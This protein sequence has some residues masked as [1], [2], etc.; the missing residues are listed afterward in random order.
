MQVLSNKPEK[1]LQGVTS[2][3]VGNC[4]FSPY[5]NGR[6][7]DLRG[8]ANGILFGDNGWGWSSAAE[9]LLDVHS[10]SALASVFSLVGHGSLRVAFAGLRQG[11]LDASIIEAMESTLDEALADGAAGFS[12]GLMYAP[13]ASAPSDELERLCRIVAR[14]GKIY[15]SHIRDYS[16]HLLQA[17]DEQVEL[18]RTTG[19]RLQISHL[20]AVGRANWK[21]NTLALEK[22]EAARHSGVDVMFDCYPYVAGSTVLTQL[23]PQWALDGGVTALMARLTD[24][25][26]R[27]EIA[28]Q[29]EGN[30]VHRWSDIFISSVGSSKN[31]TAIGK[32]IDEL[33]RSRSQSPI[34]IVFD[35][36]IEEQGA[37]NMLT[38]N[39]S[40]ENLRANLCHPLSIIISDGFYVKGKPHPRLHG[41]FPEL[42]GNICRDKK[43]LPL[44]DAINK[45]TAGPAERFAIKG[46]GLL[47]PGYFA[48]VTVFDPLHVRSNST[49]QQP[50]LSPDGVTGV[51]RE[52]KILLWNGPERPVP[53]T[54]A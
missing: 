10:R 31:S 44:P 17:I 32:S 12:T 9:Y 48:D 41:T 28:A 14:R 24:E 25:Q 37:V 5:P 19:C 30:L 8:F 39:Q 50:D 51:I 20:Q 34:D 4:G 45:V 13:G 47:Q 53:T 52:G 22:I 54:T 16:T 21:L 6:P 27:K 46:R 42:L 35:L 40:E 7:D 36:L 26:S 3:V 23:L 11:A 2:E 43:W 38:F 18:A 33:S 49:Y 15:C 29:T 1:L